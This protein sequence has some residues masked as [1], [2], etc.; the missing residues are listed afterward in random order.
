[1]REDM[2]RV[3]ID[4]PR[5]GGDRGRKRR[6]VP[7]EDLPKQEGMR[8][9]HILSGD[10]KSQKDHL[11]PLRRYLERQVGRPWDKVYA[12]I[13]EHLRA[14]CTVQ[15]HL[16]EHL[17]GFVAV[18]PRRGVRNWMFS[19][20]SMG[21]WYQPLYVDPKDGLLK[22]TDALPEVKALRRRRREPVAPSRI[23]LAP[24]RELRRIGGIW[25]ELTLA[26]L[27]EPGYRSTRRVVKVPLKVRPGSRVV[28]QEM[29]ARHL[30]TPPVQ[31][32]ASGAL[33]PVG[34]ETDDPQAWAKYRSEHPDRRYAV[35]KRTLSR[36]ELRRHGVRNEPPEA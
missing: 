29:V 22:R 33:V 10:W 3:I 31:D 35:A 24:D 27:P 13:A 9:R 2:W 34:P 25:Y 17:D 19:G 14:D 12:E 32:A 7:L 6:P 36:T 4:R 16:R 11:S 15:Q 5:R 30:I 20:N 23:A 26:P 18:K 8:R 21:L 28:E 1:M